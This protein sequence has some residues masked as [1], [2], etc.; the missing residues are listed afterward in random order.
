MPRLACSGILVSSLVA[1][2]PKVISLV[3]QVDTGSSFSKP[4]NP[5]GMGTQRCVLDRLVVMFPCATVAA[6]PIT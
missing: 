5:L 3:A 2:S 4:L 1:Q 6:R